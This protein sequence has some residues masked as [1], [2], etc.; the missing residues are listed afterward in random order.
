MTESAAVVRI[1]Y[2]IKCMIIRMHVVEGSMRGNVGKAAA[3]ESDKS[4][5]NTPYFLSGPVSHSHC[6][7]ALCIGKI[8]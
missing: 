7:S 8:I 3:W 4:T 2:G 5:I 6:P 1:N